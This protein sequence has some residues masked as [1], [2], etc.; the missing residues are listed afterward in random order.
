MKRTT[1]TDLAAEA[2][3][4]QHPPGTA[5]REL[6]DWLLSERRKAAKKAAAKTAKQRE[7]DALHLAK[8]AHGT[9]KKLQA[10][11]TAHLGPTP[12]PKSHLVFQP[13]DHKSSVDAALESGRL[14]R[15]AKK[16]RRPSGSSDT[17]SQ[18]GRYRARAYRPGLSEITAGDRTRRRRP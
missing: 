2:R 17:L 9:L 8:T 14:W 16:S 6:E 3:L 7:K 15:E 11:M 13:A 1:T 5:G 18:V 4:L 10:V 12:G